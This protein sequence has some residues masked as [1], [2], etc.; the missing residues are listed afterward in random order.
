[1]RGISSVNSTQ[2]FCMKLTKAVSFSHFVSSR[3]CVERPCCCCS[4]V[5][6]VV[7]Y[8]WLSVVVVVFVVVVQ[9]QLACTRHVSCGSR[10]HKRSQCVGRPCCRCCCCCSCCCVNVT[11][12]SSSIC[13]CCAVTTRLYPPRILWQSPTQEIA[14]R[15]ETW[16]VKCVFAGRWSL[17]FIHFML[18][19]SILYGHWLSADSQ[20][21]SIIVI[22]DISPLSVYILSVD[23]IGISPLL[24]DLVIC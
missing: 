20:P 17:L 13:C 7:V 16:S 14:M 19:S 15:G 4:V 6:V 3:A 11:D 12:C 2:S 9:W 24:A 5:V 21:P 8:V 22:I 1:M 18:P 23:I 10:R